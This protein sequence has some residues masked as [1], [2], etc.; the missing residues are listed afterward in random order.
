MTKS[1]ATSMLVQLSSYVAMLAMSGADSVETAGVAGIRLAKLAL[2]ILGERA[3]TNKYRAACNE[4]RIFT[5][6]MKE[7]TGT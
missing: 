3:N 7:R 2:P 6:Q 5:K 4:L 1:E